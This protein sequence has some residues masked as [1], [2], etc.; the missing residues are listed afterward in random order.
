MVAKYGW[1]NAYFVGGGLGIVLLL[2]RLGTFESGM[3]QEHS[4]RQQGI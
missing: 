2:L 4:S 3:Y 1:R